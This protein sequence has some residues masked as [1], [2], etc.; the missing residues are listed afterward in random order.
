MLSQN[1]KI[2]FRFGFFAVLHADSF[3]EIAGRFPAACRESDKL[4]FPFE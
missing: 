2:K 1:P 4:K 3:G